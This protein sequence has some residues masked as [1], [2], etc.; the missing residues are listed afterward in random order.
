MAPQLPV[1]RQYLARFSGALAL[2]MG[3]TPRP[4]PATLA[5]P[6]VPSSNSAFRNALLEQQLA[7]ESSP[8]PAESPTLSSSACSTKPGLVGPASSQPRK[9][10]PK[11]ILVL[12]ESANPPAQK[13]DPALPGSPEPQKTEEE[14]SEAEGDQEASLDDPVGAVETPGEP[15]FSPALHPTTLDS[16]QGPGRCRSG[17]RDEVSRVAKELH[18]P[19]TGLSGIAR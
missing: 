11:Y 17:P 13:L 9:G 10:A 18:S 8:G 6:A 16:K 1:V 3:A 14:V 19:P 15:P 4:V 7:K 12:A 5:T 2:N